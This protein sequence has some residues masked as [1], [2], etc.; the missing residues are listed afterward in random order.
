MKLFKIIRFF[1]DKS[2][3]VIKTGLTEKEAQEHCKR[4]DTHGENWFD[5]YEK[6]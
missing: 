4:E 2:N 1:K 5:G 3:R 6:E